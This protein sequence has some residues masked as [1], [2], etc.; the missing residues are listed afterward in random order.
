MAKKLSGKTADK[1]SKEKIQL[2]LS[3]DVALKLRLAALG[4]HMDL[5]EFVTAWIIREYSG[6]HIRGLEKSNSDAPELGKG[7]GAAV[8]ISTMSRIGDIARRSTSPVDE[9]LE[10]FDQD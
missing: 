1:E 5:S 10:G 4:N 8:K 9:A 3:P 7:S 2:T 6:V